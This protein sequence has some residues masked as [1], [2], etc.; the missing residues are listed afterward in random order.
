MKILS[1]TF[2]FLILTRVYAAF[3]Y[4]AISAH[5]AGLAN[6]NLASTIAPDGFLLNPALSVNAR[7]FYAGL[8]YFQ[9][10]NLKELT[11]SSGQAAFSFKGFGFGAGI[12]TFGA[13]LYRENRITLNSSKTILKNKLAVGLSVNIYNISV[14][15]YSNI[16]S[17]GLDLGFRF[18]LSENWHIAGVVENINQPKLNGH[19]EELP[20]RI[21]FGFEYR[22]TDQLYSNVSIQKDAWFDPAVL[23]GVEYNLSNSLGILSG[24]SSA[25]SLPSGGISL[26]VLNINISYSIQHHFELGPTHFIGIAYNPGG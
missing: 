24:F 22:V 18:S 6:S 17:F 8:N 2:L 11:Y 7:S 13:T 5:N 15:N 19:A 20:N 9:L 21:Q 16:N 3:D 10:F 1:I 14:Q 12:Q 4:P 25:A 23:V 26:N